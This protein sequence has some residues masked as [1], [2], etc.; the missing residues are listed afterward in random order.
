MG[1]HS[2][3]QAPDGSTPKGCET[4]GRRANP[5]DPVLLDFTILIFWKDE[6]QH[7]S[8]LTTLHYSSVLWHRGEAPWGE[9]DHR[10][11]GT[12]RVSAQHRPSHGKKQSVSVLHPESER[13][14]FP[15][16]TPS[17]KG[18]RCHKPLTVPSCPSTAQKHGLQ[19]CSPTWRQINVH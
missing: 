6:S 17:P 4:Q 3:S 11:P 19:R 9:R 16:E 18:E 10:C 14:G 8:H 1:Q 7:K 2:P 5:R 13:V 15:A 12:G